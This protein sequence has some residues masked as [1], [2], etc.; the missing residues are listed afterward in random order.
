MLLLLKLW[1]EPPLRLVVFSNAHML[2]KRAIRRL[3]DQWTRNGASAHKTREQ[4]NGERTGQCQW[5]TLMGSRLRLPL[6]AAAV[7]SHVRSLSIPF[8]DVQAVFIGYTAS[9][10][11]T[12]GTEAV[13]PPWDGGTPAPPRRQVSPS[14]AASAHSPVRVKLSVSA[15]AHSDLLYVEE[16]LSAALLR[17]SALYRRCLGAAHRRELIEAVTR[18]IVDGATAEDVFTRRQS[19]RHRCGRLSFKTTEVPLTGTGGRLQVYEA[20]EAALSLISPLEC[21]MPSHFDTGEAPADRPGRDDDVVSLLVMYPLLSTRSIRHVLLSAFQ[22]R[23]ALLSG[24]GDAAPAAVKATEVDRTDAPKEVVC[25]RSATGS[26]PT[27]ALAGPPDHFR[28]RF[29]ESRRRANECEQ[30]EFEHLVQVAEARAAAAAAAVAAAAVAKGV[31]TPSCAPQAPLLSQ[32]YVGYAEPAVLLGLWTSTLLFRAPT[33]ADVMALRGFFFTALRT[34]Y[35]VSHRTSAGAP[36]RAGSTDGGTAGDSVKFRVCDVDVIHVDYAD[37]R[38]RSRRSHRLFGVRASLCPA[39]A[40]VPHPQSDAGM[41]GDEALREGSNGDLVARELALLEAILQQS[42]E[43]CAQTAMFFPLWPERRDSNDSAR[44]AT[45]RQSNKAHCV[46]AS[47]GSGATGVRRLPFPF[48]TSSAAHRPFLSFPRVIETSSAWTPLL[49]ELRLASVAAAQRPSLHLTIGSRVVL[50]ELVYL[51]T[52]DGAVAQDGDAEKETARSATKVPNS[53]VFW[54]GQV[55]EVTGFVPCGLLL[56]CGAAS[57]GPEKA[58]EAS[59]SD[60]SATRVSSI[61]ALVQR[62]AASWSLRER[63]LIEQYVAQQRHASALPLLRCCVGSQGRQEGDPGSQGRCVFVLA[64]RCAFV[65][66]YRSLHYYGLPLLHLPLLILAGGS[67]RSQP[68]QSTVRRS[69]VCRSARR[70]WMK[71]HVSAPGSDTGTRP[72][73]LTATS[74]SVSFN[75][76]LPHLFHPYHTDPASCRATL[77]LTSQERQH[78]LQLLFAPLRNAAAA[79]RDVHVSRADEASPRSPISFVEDVL[80]SEVAG[81]HG[82]GDSADDGPAGKHDRTGVHAVLAPPLHCPLLTELALYSRPQ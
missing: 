8:G 24:A 35:A 53:V 55:C 31:A 3:V 63:Q 48:F 59:R 39:C 34:S 72:E 42:L 12:E 54:R 74:P 37:S 60:D 73:P 19:Q 82:N 30:R 80:F 5:R 75:Y 17:A 26:G 46:T 81:G 61:P 70:T 14:S 44:C 7:L 79:P 40:A 58:G 51:P 50:L 21:V 62:Q 49:T 57:K 52:S 10:A 36:P 4:Q 43:E 29:V 76:A 20:C 65:G 71:P 41:V 18:S 33:L 64:P 67:A 9:Q 16:P 45:P 13:N 68:L 32:A 25:G 6:D 22:V 66:G 77:F 15:S 78:A 27:S 56:G 47:D 11:T 28:V 1:L 23:V 69:K 2:S 38:R